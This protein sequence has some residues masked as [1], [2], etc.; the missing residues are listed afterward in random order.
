MN[1]YYYIYQD[2]H[3]NYKQAI[4][5]EFIASTICK[6]IP[7]QSVT[8]IKEYLHKLNNPV[9]SPHLLRRLKYTNECNYLGLG[10]ITIKHNQEK[11]LVTFT[12]PA[13][14]KPEKATMV[15]TLQ[16]ILRVQIHEDIPQ[17]AIKIRYSATHYS[18][19]H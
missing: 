5:P 6:A 1:T 9:W 18:R 11:D 19:L 8:S 12:I 15:A 16:R 10:D 17:S 7:K 4:N 3:N 2:S 14:Y 13:T